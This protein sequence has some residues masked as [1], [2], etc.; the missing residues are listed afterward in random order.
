MRTSRLLLATTVAIFVAADALP[1]VC[2]ESGD[3]SA[4]YRQAAAVFVGRVVTL[5]VA[6]NPAREPGEDD[7]VATL[8]VERLWKG[9]RTSTL[10]VRTC[11][12]QA[13]AC[14]CGFDFQLGAR[15]VV[16]ASG[17]RLE[18]TSCDRTRVALAAD[19]IIREIETLPKERA[20]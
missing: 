5:E 18:T 11:G 19:D 17:K 10:R 7:M 20:R 3:V 13:A 14:T 9:P 1:C 16:F 12:T 6:P 4:A 15:Y 2:P 8:R